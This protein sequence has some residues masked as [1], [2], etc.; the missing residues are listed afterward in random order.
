MYHKLQKKD[1]IEI[2]KEILGK[3]NTEIII[4][5]RNYL[6]SNNIKDEFKNEK[7]VIF[8]KNLESHKSSLNTLINPSKPKEIDFAD[9]TDKPI[10]NN[11]MNR[12]LEQM[13]KDRNMETNSI[14]IQANSIELETNSIELETNSIELETNTKEIK[15]S[16][17]KIIK[18]NSIMSETNNNEVPKIKIE[19]I[20]ELLES[21]VINLNKTV[22]KNTHEFKKKDEKFK[23]ISELLENEY[24]KEESLNSNDK[25]DTI[26]K[27]LKKLLL[28]QEKIMSKLE[29]L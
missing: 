12:I 19:S 18:Q 5:K 29:L 3:L 13:Q 16:D 25:L 2:N 15:I 7:K 4:L 17:D 23:S 11:E 1:I 10:D 28:N 20:E 21:E 8:D 14:E 27:V 22:E 6:E 9:E 26:N 24:R